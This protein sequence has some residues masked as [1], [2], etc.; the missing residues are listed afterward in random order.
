MMH[1]TTGRD[2]K[3]LK[4]VCLCLCIFS[5][6]IG[7]AQDSWH[8]VPTR[9][10]GP[11]DPDSIGTLVDAVAIRGKI[12]AP[13]R[14]VVFGARNS[15]ILLVG[16]WI[17]GLTEVIPEDK[18]S[19]YQRPVVGHEALNPHMIEITL[20]SQGRQV[21]LDSRMVLMSEF[22]L[23]GGVDDDGSDAI[24]VGRHNDKP[25]MALIRR[26][27]DGFDSGTVWIGRGVFSPPVEVRFKGDGIRTSLKGVM[28]FVERGIVPIGSPLK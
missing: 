28:D 15:G 2:M 12:R 19:D 8:L 13:A 9:P 17:R 10:R 5:P 20:F 26:M 24:V 1:L 18:L 27:S 14:V 11:R 22:I 21:Q 4:F 6:V 3:I 25:F 16:V 23:P 7:V